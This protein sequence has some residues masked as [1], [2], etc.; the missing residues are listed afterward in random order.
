MITM[1][2]S[3]SDHYLLSTKTSTSASEPLN[4]T[5]LAPTNGNTIIIH[6]RSRQRNNLKQQR[7]QKKTQSYFTRNKHSAFNMGVQLSN[8]LSDPASNVVTLLNYNNNKPDLGGSTAEYHLIQFIPGPPGSAPEAR[9][10]NFT[11]EVKCSGFV[12][13]VMDAASIC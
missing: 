13:H 9:L 2:S 8:V 12:D 6:S 5:P 10:G 11:R 7:Q 1:Q 4:S 3:S